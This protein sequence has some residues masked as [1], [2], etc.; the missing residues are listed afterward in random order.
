M[1]LL[2]LCLLTVFSYCHST[3]DGLRGNCVEK[4]RDKH[5]DDECLS[6]WP[7]MRCT[8]SCGMVNPN[9]CIK[10]TPLTT[11]TPMASN[12]RASPAS[13]PTH[14]QISLKDEFSHI[15]IMWNKMDY[16]TCYGRF[17]CATTDPKQT[18]SCGKFVQ[19][20]KDWWEDYQR[21]GYNRDIFNKAYLFVPGRCLPSDYK[22]MREVL[23]PQLKRR[24]EQAI[25]K[26]KELE[27]SMAG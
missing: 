9:D 11:R 6:G 1:K 25:Q 3:C 10:R 27:R 22:E 24:R 16:S 19:Y 18:G 20:S 26:I 13:P 21:Y 2:I 17:A 4:C 8:W 23:M 15:N 7:W 5:C 14:K 12:R